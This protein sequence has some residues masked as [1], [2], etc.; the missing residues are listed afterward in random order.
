MA[1]GT[2]CKLLKGKSPEEQI[3]ICLNC[4]Y[5][6]CVFDIPNT[7]PNIEARNRQIR[8]VARQGIPREELMSTFNLSN[9]TLVRI[10]YE[11][12]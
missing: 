8:E 7:H 11:N 6:R 3:Q 9:R 4:P 1:D 12:P 10:L 5:D 2:S